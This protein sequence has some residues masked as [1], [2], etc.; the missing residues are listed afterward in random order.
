MAPERSL[1]FS[2]VAER[3]RLFGRRT[4]NGIFTPSLSLSLLKGG[5]ERGERDRGTLG[6]R[7]RPGTSPGAA[8]IADRHMVGAGKRRP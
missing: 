4:R 3:G 6:V 7:A 2:V 1:F 8:P 5:V